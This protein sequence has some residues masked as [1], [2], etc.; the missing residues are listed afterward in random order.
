MSKTRFDYFREEAADYL[1]QLG[2]LLAAK[3]PPMEALIR[4]ARGLRGSATLAGPPALSRAT[5]ELERGIKGLGD[6]TFDWPSASAAIRQ[7]VEGLLNLVSSS[8]PWSDDNDRMATRVAEQL[9][10]ALGQPAPVAQPA[11]PAGGSAAM[12]AFMAQEG[13]SVAAAVELALDR[14]DQETIRQAQVAMQTVQGLAGLNEH[15]PL[16]ELLN[17]LEVV[18]AEFAG[19][20]ALPGEARGALARFVTVLR[21]TSDRLAAGSNSGEEDPGMADL[22]RSTHAALYGPG[23]VVPIETLLIGPMPESGVRYGTGATGPSPANPIELSALGDSLRYA[24]QQLRA[25]PTALTFRLAVLTQSVVL[26]ASPGGLGHR[27]AGPF[28]AD[29][30]RRLELAG[31]GHSDPGL[32][33]LLD[34]AGTMLAQQAGGDLLQLGERLAELSGDEIVSIDDLLAAAAPPTSASHIAEPAR[35]RTALERS[36]TSYARLVAADAPPTPLTAVTAPPT[37]SLSKADESDVVPIEALLLELPNGGIVPIESLL[38]D[39]EPAA[40]PIEMLL[41]RGRRALER[42]N[43][44]RKTLEAAISESPGD[45]KLLQPMM[46]ELFDLVPLALTSDA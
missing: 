10:S 27:P 5:R 41:Y 39:G 4:L 25:A 45:V 16:P 24:A 7:A 43:Q 37:A 29:T 14:G 13:I 44:I 38:F 21:R 2:P 17:A 26:R 35:D 33:E 34:A 12:R 8:M 30:L 18:L 40:V 23:M 22:A 11:T 46:L 42:A 15:P 36:F 28:L 20:Q 19:Y 6:G 1:R 3:S 32:P 9:G 31:A